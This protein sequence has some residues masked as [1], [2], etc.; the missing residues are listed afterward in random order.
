MINCSLACRSA[1]ELLHQVLS[2]RAVEP[3]VQANPRLM[4]IGALHLRSTG[5]AQFD[6]AAALPVH[7]AA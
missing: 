7:E 3:T 6:L 5:P 2:S 4:T 1:P